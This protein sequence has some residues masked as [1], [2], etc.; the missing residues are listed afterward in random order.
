MAHLVLSIPLN[1]PDEKTQVIA[2][3]TVAV[4][5]IRNSETPIEIF[6]FIALS[7]PPL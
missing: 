6:L 7:F 5:A 3:V 4:I 1:T 2:N